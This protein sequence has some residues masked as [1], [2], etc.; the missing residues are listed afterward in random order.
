[1]TE[2]VRYNLYKPSARYSAT[3]ALCPKTLRALEAPDALRWRLSA[4]AM[5][6]DAGCAAVCDT[7]SDAVLD[8]AAAAVAAVK[9]LG[10]DDPY[11]RSLSEWFVVIDDLAD[12]DEQ[13]PEPPKLDIRGLLDVLRTQ[14][15]AAHDAALACWRV[16]RGESVASIAASD[17][18]TEATD[19]TASWPARGLVGKRKR[20]KLS[21]GARKANKAAKDADGG[22]TNKSCTDYRAA[23]N[24][25]VTG[26]KRNCL[27]CSVLS[28]APPSLSAKIT[29]PQLEALA[30]GSDLNTS[31]NAVDTFLQKEAKWSLLRVSSEFQN[32]KGGA[33]LAVLQP[34]NRLLIAQ[35]AVTYDNSDKEPDLHCVAY[36][37]V[38]VKDNWQH[39]KVKVIDDTDR[40]TPEQARAV[41]DSLFPGLKVR[42]CNVY[43]LTS[44]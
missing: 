34:T 38:V 41:F 44:L 17:R 39:S 2:I 14:R 40:A 21:R 22:Y 13:L 16:L 5:A 28:L 1:M 31:F 27:A 26:N 15:Q 6:L 19:A 33:A 32:V 11:G 30:P 35:L 9:A 25:F 7:E 24:P 18:N 23:G 36:D 3:A 4:R 12:S 43:E 37:G 8:A 10:A 29:L 42:V 20:T